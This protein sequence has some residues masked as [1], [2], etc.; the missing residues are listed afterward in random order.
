MK[1]TIE[2][3]K[4]MAILDVVIIIMTLVYYETA[5]TNINAETETEEIPFELEAVEH[6]YIDT[7][8][9]EF[10]NN[11]LD[12]RTVIG[13]T[14][15]ANGLQLHTEDGNGYYLDT[16]NVQD[17]ATEIY[18]M[19]SKKDCKALYKKLLHRNGKIIIEVITGTVDDAEGNGTDAAGY[20]IGYD[21]EKFSKG[22]KVQSVFVYNPDN[23]YTDDILYRVDTLIK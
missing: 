2:A 1:K 10:R 5:Q 8:T 13:Y 7:T 11:Y 22:D 19:T 4:F 23:N 6:D 12:M 14:G 15:T 3:I 21:M 20:Y 18:T 17:G 9:E 16:G